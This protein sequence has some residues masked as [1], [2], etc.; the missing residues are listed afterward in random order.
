[1][2]IAERP[3]RSF[4]PRRGRVTAAQAAA[5]DQLWPG[6]GV[7]V[8][9][10]RLDL[11]ELFGNRQPT[12]L[13]IGFGSGD[14]TAAMAADDQGVN[15]LAVD[16]HTPGFGRL[17]Q[18]IGSDG[19]GNVRV[20]SGDAVD[21]LRDMLEPG[22]LAGIRIFFPDPWPKARHHKRR[23]IQPAFAS[24][25]A[26]RLGIGG[27]LHLASDWAPYVDQMRAVLDAE[28]LLTRHRDS[29]GERLLGRPVTRYEQAGLAQGHEV[30]DLV[31]TRV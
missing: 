27:W 31:Y 24:L 19:L 28:Q 11:A 17:L 8:D 26:S 29:A 3:I 1:V 15:L 21:L 30:V 22:A 4:H 5:I 14:A 20:A 9:G 7:D 18:R 10:R 23:L 13:E 16:I 25:A 2:T 12:V 6:Y